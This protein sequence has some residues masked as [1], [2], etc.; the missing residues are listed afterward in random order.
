MRNQTQR[1]RGML[2]SK[3]LGF[4]LDYSRPNIGLS[5]FVLVHVVG[6]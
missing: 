2:S 6:L 1:E 4:K 3:R 5:H